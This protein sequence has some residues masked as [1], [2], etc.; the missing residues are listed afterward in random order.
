MA[1]KTLHT[2]T[3]H[4]EIALYKICK[5]E[6]PLAGAKETLFTS[7][8][9]ELKN[10]Y[11]KRTGQDTVFLWSFFLTLLRENKEMIS[12]G[13]KKLYIGYKNHQ[14]YADITLSYED[15][16]EYDNIVI[17]WRSYLDAPR[18]I[19]FF[20]RFITDTLLASQ[21]AGETE[22]PLL[23]GIKKVEYSTA[24]NTYYRL[25]FSN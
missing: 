9:K 18:A 20:Q 12:K 6:E 7:F 15:K 5:M 2:F 19:H 25:N 13:G 23:E 3:A 1:V 10:T 17:T 21:E 4:E 8:H 22:D 24:G 16:M 11:S 14:Y